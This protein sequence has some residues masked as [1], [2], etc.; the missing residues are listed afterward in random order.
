LLP[1]FCG[2]EASGQSILVA[3]VLLIVTSPCSPARLARSSGHLGVD[4]ATG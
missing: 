4:P 1:T 2:R 3:I